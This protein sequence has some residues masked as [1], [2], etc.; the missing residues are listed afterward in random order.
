VDVSFLSF[1]V[2]IVDGDG[3]IQARKR[4]NGYIEFNLA[5]S[6]HN[7]DM[8]TFEYLLGKL[9]FGVIAKVSSTVSRLIIYNFELKYIL[10]PLLL[11]HG[12]FFLTENRIN[13]YN[14]LLY[15]LEH[16]IKK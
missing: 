1:L 7:R 12:L 2:G 11:K 6:F 3:Y 13:Q 4:Y 10:V 14:L 9:H 8:A 15:T 16:N 5:I